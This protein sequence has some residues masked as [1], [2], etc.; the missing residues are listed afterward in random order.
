MKKLVLLAT[1]VT[2]VAFAQR[3]TTRSG[4][5]EVNVNAGFTGGAI[6]LGGTYEK[7]SGNV[8]WGG[9]FDLQTEK[10][11]AG[12][13]QVMSFGGM[14]KVHVVQQNNVDAYIAPGFGIAMIQGLGNADDKTVVGPS[15][16]IGAQY[17]VSPTVKVGVERLMLNNWFDDEAPASVEYTTAVV[18]FSF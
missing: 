1:L 3:S 7:D 16:K 14:M 15:M 5:A 4:D 6:N 12:V 13:N 10:E 18:G 17:F 9:Y 8:G 2:S 11:K